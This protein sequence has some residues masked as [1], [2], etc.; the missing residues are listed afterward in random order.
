MTT[1]IQWPVFI[2]NEGNFCFYLDFFSDMLNLISWITLAF[3]HRLMA[4]LCCMQLLNVI[5]V[6]V[7]AYWLF[8][9]QKWKLYLCMFIVQAI[10]KPTW[11]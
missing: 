6:F 3:I 7:V 2:H 5:L 11:I 4:F 8:Y 10:D 1:A 9:Y